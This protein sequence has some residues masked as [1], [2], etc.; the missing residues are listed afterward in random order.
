LTGT[1]EGLHDHTYQDKEYQF[2]E[3]ADG[4]GLELHDFHARMYDATTGRWLVPDPAAQFA[5]PYLAMGNNPINGIDPDGKA[6][7][8]D[9]LIIGTIAFIAGYVY[10]GATTGEWGR[11]ALLTGAKWA[12]TAV[13][14]Y[15]TMGVSSSPAFAAAWGSKYAAAS[16]AS[17][18]MPSVNIPITDN[19]SVSI[20]P[21]II[22]G[23]EG[24]GIGGNIGLNYTS[25]TTSVSIGYGITN[26]DR[27]WG[28]NQPTLESRIYGGVNTGNWSFGLTNFR[29]GGTNQMN[30]QVGFNDGRFSVYVD[31]DYKFS[32]KYRTGLLQIGYQFTDEFGLNT[33]FKIFTGD[34]KPDGN[35][36][37]RLTEEMFDKDI[38]N[39]KMHEFNK[40]GSEYRSG[41]LYGGFNVNGFNY[42]GGWSSERIRYAVQ[43]K[44]IHNLTNDPYFPYVH[45]PAHYYFRVGSYQPFTHY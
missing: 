22:F 30:W 15:N 18:L 23:S 19:F 43:N 24:F 20:S 45:Y 28:T 14:T 42:Q 2:A 34:P 16:A 11:E 21:T 13:I 25:G 12:I 31:E 39:R 40:D 10:H 41:I 27:A 32:D 26:Y 29:G 1:E 44:G 3:F 9:D 17:S 8:K 6:Y 37:E 35:K 38:K 33:G 4:R 7:I 5:N 36:K